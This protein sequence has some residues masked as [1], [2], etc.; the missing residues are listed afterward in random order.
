MMVPPP[1]KLG[2]VTLTSTNIPEEISSAL[3]EGPGSILAIVVTQQKQKS[4]ILGSDYLIVLEHLHIIMIFLLLLDEGIHGNKW[5]NLTN[6][7]DL[8]IYL[9]KYLQLY[10]RDLV[11]L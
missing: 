6:T 5:M 7:K 2:R 3:T 10:L 11:P 9:K 8:L 4:Q 1:K